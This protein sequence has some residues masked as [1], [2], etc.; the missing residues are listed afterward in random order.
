MGHR[1][2]DMG[3]EKSSSGYF[4]KLHKRDRQSR[5]KEKQR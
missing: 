2:L 4:R 5:R 1:Y 3:R